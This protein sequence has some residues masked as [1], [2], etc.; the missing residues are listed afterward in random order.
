MRTKKQFKDIQQSKA[1]K[2]TDFSKDRFKAPKSGKSYT[3]SK[4]ED[5]AKSGFARGF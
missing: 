5:A 2:S 4:I 1:F 3:Q